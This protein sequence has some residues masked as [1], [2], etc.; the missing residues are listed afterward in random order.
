MKEKNELYKGLQKVTQ[1]IVRIRVRSTI[2]LGLYLNK[3]LIS[4][5]TL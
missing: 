3:T 2:H 4:G 5:L 1:N